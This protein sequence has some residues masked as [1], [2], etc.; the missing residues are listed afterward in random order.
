MPF[1]ILLAAT[2]FAG[3]QFSFAFTPVRAAITSASA[4]K[5]SNLA[6][7]PPASQSQIKVFAYLEAKA[8]RKVYRPD[9]L[10]PGGYTGQWFFARQPVTTDPQTV[11]PL[12]YGNLLVAKK[13]LR[14]DNVADR[15]LGLV[16]ARYSNLWLRQSLRDTTLSPRLI[17]AFLL[18]YLDAAYSE[19]WRTVSR[20]QILEDANDAYQETHEVSHQATVLRLLI[21]SGSGVNTTDWARMAL[22]ELQASQGQYDEAADTAEAITNPSMAGG[23]GLAADWRKEADARAKAIAAQPVLDDPEAQHNSPHSKKNSP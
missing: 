23:K 7:L 12:I 3:I 19:D 9:P 17:E 14:S 11:Y 15:K 4:A 13:L 10:T 22:G 5:R 20:R 2:L 8:G 16:V 21:H 1:T 6:W 18:P